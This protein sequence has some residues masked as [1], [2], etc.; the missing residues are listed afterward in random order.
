MCDTDWLWLLYNQITRMYHVFQIHSSDINVHW[1]TIPVDRHFKFVLK[2][3]KTTRGIKKAGRLGQKKLISMQ[4]VS[5]ELTGNILTHFHENPFVFYSHVNIFL[6]VS[7]NYSFFQ[8]DAL[9]C[10]VSISTLLIKW[11]RLAG[12]SNKVGTNLSFV[13]HMVL[14]ICYNNK[15]YHFKFQYLSAK[16]ENKIPNEIYG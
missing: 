16:K 6:T 2:T 4:A 8:E 7:S 11:F 9:K 10:P 14:G 12:L 5:T 13:S 1:T 15:W 3:S